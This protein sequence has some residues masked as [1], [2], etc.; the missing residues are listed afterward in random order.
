[1]KLRL[2]LLN[3]LFYRGTGPTGPA[4]GTITSTYGRK[5]DTTESSISLEANIGQDI[6]LGSNGPSNGIT[7]G[8]QNK[9]T[10]PSNGIYKVD[11]YFS[12]GASV[13]TD[14]TVSV[15]QNSTSIGSTTINKNVTA[16]VDTDFVGS[17]INSFNQGDQIGLFIES[18]NAAT[19]SPSSDTSAY[20]NI[21]KIS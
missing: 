17:T 7:L 19:I 18:T 12:G 5:Y 20:L 15:K 6:P 8:T 4:G 21:V 11:F 14:L 10:I 13:N 16:N 1:M 2:I 9:L 3:D